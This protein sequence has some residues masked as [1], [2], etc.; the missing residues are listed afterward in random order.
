LTTEEE[1]LDTVIP[2]S[3]IQAAAIPDQEYECCECFGTFED[4]ITLGNQ[5][6]W[7]MCTCVKW[8]NK[9][10]ISETVLDANGKLRMC[11]GCVVLYLFLIVQVLT[12]IL[13]I[14]YFL[15]LIL[16]KICAYN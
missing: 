8:L 9:D 3:E 1:I 15:G 2:T 16:K 5:A 6:E 7:T 13:I 10:C 11:S 12:I 14:N 4:D